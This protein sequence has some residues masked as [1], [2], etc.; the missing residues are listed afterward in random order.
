MRAVSVVVALDATV[1]AD[2]VEAA[3]TGDSS[4]PGLRARV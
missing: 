3:L 2:A 1:D 4:G